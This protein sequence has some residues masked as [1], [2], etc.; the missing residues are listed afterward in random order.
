LTFVR[1]DL[2]DGIVGGGD[3]L[4]GR[5]LVVMVQRVT[6]FDALIVGPLTFVREM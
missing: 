1:K 5:G 3:D 2:C 4:S 6:A